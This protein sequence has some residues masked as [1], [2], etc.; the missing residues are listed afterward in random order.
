MTHE[1]VCLYCSVVTGH[2]DRP[3]RKTVCSRVECTSEHGRDEAREVATGCRPW[4]RPLS[5]WVTFFG[6]RPMPDIEATAAQDAWNAEQD[7]VRAFNDAHAGG[8]IG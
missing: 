5:F 4:A 7:R 6:Y 2:S 8:L 3:G 1:C